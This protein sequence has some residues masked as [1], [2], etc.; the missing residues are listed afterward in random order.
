MN[1]TTVSDLTDLFC[2]YSIECI[3]FEHNDC[4]ESSL[5]PITGCGLASTR[6]S[7]RQK[8]GLE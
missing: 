4:K 2:L 3:G 7:L 5:S 1:S 6:G 8:V